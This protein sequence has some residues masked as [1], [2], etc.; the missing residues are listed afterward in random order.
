MLDCL[1]D[2]GI[3]PA[4]A[5][6][7]EHALACAPESP[8]GPLGMRFAAGKPIYVVRAPARLDCMG[9]IADYSGSLVCEMTLDRAVLMGLQARDDRK[10]VVHS[11]G[12]DELGLSPDVTLA[13]DD[14]APGPGT[15]DY[16]TVK[17]GISSAPESAW[18]AYVAGAFSVL[19]GEG[20]MDRFPHGATIVLASNIP[21]RVG[22][23]S[24]AA[25]EIAAMHGLSLLYGISLDGMTLAVLSQKVENHVVGAACGIMD[26][27]TCALGTRGRMLSLLCQPH[28]L[29]EQIPIPDGIRF[30]GINSGVRREIKSA[31]YTD[32]RIGAFIGL[33]ILRDHLRSGNGAAANL[34][35]GYLCNLS[36]TEYVDACRSLLPSSISGRTFTRRYGTTPDP[37]TVV[38][39]EVVYKVRSRVE[40]PVYEHRRVTDFT[41]YIRRAGSSG[42]QEYLERAG[43]LMY[44]SDWS[45]T[46][47]CGLGSAETAWIV[48]EARKLGVEAGFYG[49][50][51]TGGGAGGTVAVAGND[52]MFD[53][54]DRLLKRYGEATGIEAELFTGTSPGA[55]EF[56]HR[57]Y[58]IP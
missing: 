8:Y 50:R 4:D 36:T 18:A 30:I 22:A 35:L 5:A 34:R 15:V 32:S 29:R 20:H 52:R 14:L 31:R 21:L 9:G 16:D 19:Q 24:S 37:V 42:Q 48:R 41:D 7:F 57:V 45:Y 55:L 47:R 39:P 53:H 26:Q 54:L 10:V 33:A 49:A 38:D 43:R 12:V 6:A 58:R 28:T 23:S 51:I 11:A 44:A 2:R 13:L 3:L 17:R 25:L 27:V 40:H 1:T 46:H 56:G